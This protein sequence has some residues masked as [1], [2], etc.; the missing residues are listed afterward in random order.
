MK[1][2]IFIILS[3]FL[4]KNVR[5]SDDIT[6]LSLWNALQETN[7]LYPEVVFAQAV[8]ESGHFKSSVFKNH[9]NLFGMKYPSKRE[10]FAFGKSKSG[11]A[12]FE[13]WMQSILDYKIWQENFI[14]RHKIQSKR[15]YLLA[16]NKSYSETA[17]YSRYLDKIIKS[18]CFL[19]G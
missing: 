11:Y 17:N 3:F 15:E 5:S 10:T 1:S 19:N 18:F 9:K 13:D 16:L 8:L 12:K 4:F 2:I 14:L 7:I 6:Y